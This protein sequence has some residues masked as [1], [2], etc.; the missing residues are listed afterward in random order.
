MVPED[1]ERCG[2][3]DLPEI[4]PLSGYAELHLLA[5]EVSATWAWVRGQ[6]IPAQGRNYRL[7]AR[8]EF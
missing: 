6:E 2:N 3:R 4:P 5:H 7:W 1:H 8:W